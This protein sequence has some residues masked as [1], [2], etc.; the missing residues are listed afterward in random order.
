MTSKITP[1]ILSAIGTGVSLFIQ[2]NRVLL[3]KSGANRKYRQVTVNGSEVRMEE[4]GRLVFRWLDARNHFEGIES[5]PKTMP[6]KLKKAL[7]EKLP[8]SAAP[9]PNLPIHERV[10]ILA[11]EVRQI[12]ARHR[13]NAIKTSSS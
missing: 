1:V 13:L 7:L 3:F 8:V 12:E 9:M 5:K 10:R 4:L 11:E 6:D 2:E